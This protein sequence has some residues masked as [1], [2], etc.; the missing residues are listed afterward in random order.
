MLLE[1]IEAFRK[2]GPTFKLGDV[3]PMRANHNL[4]VGRCCKA[5]ASTVLASFEANRL[6]RTIA[7]T[8]AVIPFPGAGACNQQHT[9][10]LSGKG[11][12]V[13][14][15]WRYDVDH[16]P[17]PFGGS[18]TVGDEVSHHERSAKQLKWMQGMV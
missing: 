14:G 7:L 9:T 4:Q 13:V 15:T 17:S 8:I 18:R 5:L 3:T 6:H 2:G 16:M 11:D 12:G 1:L 10:G